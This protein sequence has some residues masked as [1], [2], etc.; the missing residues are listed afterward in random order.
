MNKNLILFGLS[1]DVKRHELLRI[2]TKKRKDIDL[3]KS[4]DNVSGV[5]YDVIYKEL[6]CNAE[7]LHS[8]TSELYTSNEIEYHNNYNII[9][10]FATKNGVTSFN[11]KKYLNRIKEKRRESIRFFVQTIIPVLAL[12]VA[13]LSLSLKFDNLK[14]QSDKELEKLEYKLLKQKER[15]DNM[16]SLTNTKN[17]DSVLLKTE[18]NGQSK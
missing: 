6:K 17:M 11:N 5:S 2:L 1:L 3:R 18:T 14:M 16:E 8:I 13:T 10:V 7:E 4:K 15:I 12:V 9:G